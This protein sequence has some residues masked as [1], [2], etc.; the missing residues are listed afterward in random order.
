[1]VRSVTGGASKSSFKESI[2]GM[3]LSKQ[4]HFK[5]VFKG[6]SSVQISGMPLDIFR[7]GVRGFKPN[8]KKLRLCP[9]S[10]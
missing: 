9:I 10:A 6:N 1:M 7:K 8:H 4:G 2:I 5:T 3:I